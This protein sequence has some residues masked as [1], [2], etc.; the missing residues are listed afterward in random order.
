MFC[1]NCATPNDPGSNF[2]KQ[3]GLPIKSAGAPPAGSAPKKRGC[4]SCSGCLFTLSVLFFL[5]LGFLAYALYSGPEFINKFLA[6]GEENLKE[7]ASLPV[8][9]DD[10]D[11]LEKNLTEFLKYIQ[12]GGT[13][14]IH[15]KEIEINSYISR[16]LPVTRN[17]SEEVRLKDLKVKITEDGFKFMGVFRAL[18][19]ESY[20]AAGVKITVDENKSVSY[21]FGGIYLGKLWV[22]AL[23]FNAALNLAKNYFKSQPGVNQFTYRGVSFQIN[24]IAYL[25]SKVII[26]CFKPKTD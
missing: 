26:E 13:V 5:F 19:L 6:P 11:S 9:K 16:K 15:L 24:K 8:T 22:P 10:A 7:L 2:C 12:K 25:N 4:C 14:E 23:A 1:P 21:V 18:K 3:C 17:Q 20:F